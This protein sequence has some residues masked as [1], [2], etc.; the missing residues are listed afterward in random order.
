[1]RAIRQT[2]ASYAAGL[3]RSLARVERTG[4]LMAFVGL[5]GFSALGMGMRLLGITVPGWIEPLCHR[6]VLWLGFLGACLAVRSRAH[7]KL[8]LAQAVLPERVQAWSAVLVAPVS[9]LMCLLL[10]YASWGFILEERA[11]SDAV[12]AGVPAWIYP[13]IIP[14]GFAL[15]GLHF[16][17]APWSGVEPLRF[18]RIDDTSPGESP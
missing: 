7:I 14:V 4:A 17:L 8:D 1:M 6:L 12:L 9:G 11:A 5:L 16:L 3:D 18:E 10:A 2:L 15:M 13:T